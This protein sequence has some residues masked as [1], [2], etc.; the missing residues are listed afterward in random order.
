[1]KTK[2]YD[3]FISYRREGG[4]EMA[5]SI[6]QRLQNAGYSVF[7]DL[8]QL[9][10]GKFNEQLL[11]VIESC[12]DFILVLPENALDRCTQEDDWVR[13]E[14]EYAIKQNKN[15]IPVML[16]GFVWPHKDELPQT[17]SELP[18]Y[19][20]ISATDHKVFPENMERLKS[21]LLH[22][23]PGILW[24]KYKTHLLVSTL[25]LFVILGS[26]FAWWWKGEK[27]Y[28][29]FCNE[30]SMKM[31]LEFQNVHHNV[32]EAQY[33]LEAWND[34]R[35][36]RFSE[37]INT[38]RKNLTQSLNSY[39]KKLLKPNNLVLNESEK[40][41]FRKHGVEIEKIE[42][43]YL[44]G[45]LIYNDVIEFFDI[46]E[47][48][49]NEKDITGIFNETVNNQFEI[50]KLELEG[51]YCGLLSN[52]TDMP[53]SVY[54]KLMTSKEVLLLV[55][56]IPMQLSRAEYEAQM[57]L[58]IN[59]TD[60][61]AHKMG[62]DLYDMKM[63]VAQR[64]QTLAN[65]DMSNQQKLE[66]LYEGYLEECVIDETENQWEQWGKIQKCGL[67]LQPLIDFY[68]DFKKD[69]LEYNS[70]L[71]PEYICYY[72]QSLLDKYLLLHP[73]SEKYVNATKVFIQDV[74]ELQREYNGV[75]IF[76]FA[77][78]VLHPDLQIG[79]IIVEYGGAIVENYDELNRLYI[80][81]RNAKV[82]FLRLEGDKLVEKELPMLV[83][84]DVIG[85]LDLKTKLS[86]E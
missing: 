12:Q 58:I 2:K 82:K 33:A 74:V 13:R 75:L 36:N 84:V 66:K 67:W 42:G 35:E 5:D 20:G 60:F 41:M 56:H 26:I 65:I 57:D 70:Y 25:V 63:K 1:M 38:Q 10:S 28:E 50:I 32:I 47:Y 39:R 43:S 34:F 72:M 71:T 78:N 68:V 85:F 76:A 73:E 18:N 46:I 55:G 23:K 7:L 30:Y 11:S 29:L 81:N 62:E 3:I 15:I 22:S 69:G 21:K 4:L 6:Y 45:E 44:M 61:Y 31:M 17:L 59:K 14:V 16:R 49:S 40:Q 24:H 54:K 8:E 77:D 48:L 51:A 64:E 86:K 52:Y 53:N 37:D 19:E 9:A 79:D 83:N 27:E 80:N